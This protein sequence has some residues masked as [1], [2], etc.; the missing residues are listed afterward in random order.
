MKT[1]TCLAVASAALILPFH[2]MALDIGGIDAS[3]G[4]GGISAGVEGGGVSI[5]ASVGGS[6]ETG[7]SS[8]IGGSVGSGGGSTSGGSGGGSS[9]TGGTSGSG[10]GGTTT[11]VPS[12]PS[13]E[14]E[15]ASVS[16]APA[17]ADRAFHGPS[18]SAVLPEDLRPRRFFWWIEGDAP[19]DT[20]FATSE[21][22]IAEEVLVACRDTVAEVAEPYGMVDVSM[23]VQG[24]PRDLENGGLLAPMFTT[25]TYDRLTGHE[26]RRARIWCQ[27]DDAGKVSAL[28]DD[29]N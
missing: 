25:I 8:S 11:G 21:I 14:A 3:V 12:S 29:P 16:A 17:R 13:E 7:L 28:L 9:G 26:T 22:E 23:S 24:E 5:G 20:P 19:P 10:S 6:T 27:L 15:T 4:D 18:R 1:K 2:A